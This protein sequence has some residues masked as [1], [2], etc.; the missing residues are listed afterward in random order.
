MPLT[1]K[2]L[3][4]ELFR[5]NYLNNTIKIVFLIFFIIFPTNQALS[6]VYFVFLVISL[7]IGVT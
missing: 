2:N 7:F 5:Y 6:S 3:K 1:L 4:D